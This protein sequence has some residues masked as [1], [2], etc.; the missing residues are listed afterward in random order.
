M[1]PLDARP[2]RDRIVATIGQLQND[3]GNL[4]GR[5]DVGSGEGCI[6]GYGLVEYLARRAINVV[7]R[8]KVD[9]RW[10]GGAD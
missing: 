10:C 8:S 5:L 3:I 6:A 1:L 7:A 9:C 4:A 2:P